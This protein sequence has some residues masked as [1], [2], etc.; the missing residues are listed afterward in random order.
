MTKMLATE[1]IYFAGSSIDSFVI[2]KVVSG[3]K[4]MEGNWHLK[5]GTH[6]LVE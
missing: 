5:Y 6:I 1:T 3:C 2:S 4:S